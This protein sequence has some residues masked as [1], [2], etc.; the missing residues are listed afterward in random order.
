MTPDD[1][2]FPSITFPA[3]FEGAGT[4]GA[5][6][7]TTLKFKPDDGL[8]VLTDLRSL[9]RGKYDVTVVA[10]QSALAGDSV[11]RE[12]ANM[13]LQAVEEAEVVFAATC[14]GGTCP[15]FA[16]AT[17]GALEGAYVCGL[18]PE[19][20]V[21]LEPGQTPCPLYPQ[22]EADEE[23]GPEGQPDRPDTDEE[24]EYPGGWGEHPDEE[25]P[26]G[27]APPF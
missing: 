3:T 17:E 18:D 24:W 2:A 16:V 9:P 4:I 14:V 13:D 20:L 19:N 22:D 6:F 11:D 26:E 10:R 12:W 5:D 7:S 27:D 15:H 23:V 1:A 25:H 8:R 21:K